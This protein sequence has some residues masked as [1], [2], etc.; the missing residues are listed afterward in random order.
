MTSP[1]PADGSEVLLTDV[2]LREHG[3]NVPAA[4]LERFTVGERVALARALVDAGVR[5]IEVLSC[6][7]PRVAPAMAPELLRAVARGLG[8]PAGVEIVTLVPNVRGY[9]SFVELG[10]G[11]GGAA[12]T[13]GLFHSAVERH[14]RANLRRSIDATVREM[15]AVFRRAHRDGTRVASY[16]SAAFGYVENGRLYRVADHVLAD[17]VRRQLDLGA[18][19]VTLSDLQGLAGREETRRVWD[20]LLAL[21][22]GA[23]APRLGYHAHHADPDRAVDL[24]EAAYR[25]GVRAVDASLRATGGC[26]TGA[27]GNAPTGRVLRRLE[28]LGGLTGVDATAVAALAPPWLPASAG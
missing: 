4:D 22:G 11:A 26:V 14:N 28:A 13:V 2:T 8:R 24:V 15:S 3:Q 7:H 6:V 1:S 9:D 23:H 5:R 16:V 19:L 25:A 10:L 20:M 27:P 12:H 17:Q 18:S 21:D